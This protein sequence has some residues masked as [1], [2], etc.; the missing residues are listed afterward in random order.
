MKRTAL[1]QGV[2]RGAFAVFFAL[3]AC[4]GGTEPPK[5]PPLTADPPAGSTSADQGAAEGDVT[6]GE[7]LINHG[8]FEEAKA[9]LE[10]ALQR[11]PSARAHFGMGVVREKMKD[12]KGAEESYKEALKLDP[13]HAE[14]SGNL[15]ALYMDD[16]RPA[17]AIAVLKAATA[18]APKEVQLMRNLAYAYA[19]SG[20]VANAS[21]QYEAALKLGEDAQIRF[22][23][24]NMLFEAKQ[25]EKA[26]EQLK[27]ALPGT[28][29]DAPT[30]GTLG[31]LLSQTKAYGECVKAYD[32]AIK[33]KP[34]PEWLVRR[35]TCRHE[36]KDDTGAQ[37]DYQEAIKLDPKFATAHYYLAMAYIV[38]KQRAK[39]LASLE[40]AAKLGAG[41]P[42]GKRAKD[43]LNELSKQK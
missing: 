34:H 17:E 1:F 14:A 12:T 28:K 40:Q 18:K 3:A 10:K 35:G 9:E 38:D 33:L 32:R 6:R 23:Y 30:L 22:E 11:H 4:S 41:T 27:K 25:P 20:D 13:G 24:G 26:A 42:V 16:K 2:R 21:A 37:A 39:A 36:L 7:E 15:A 8:K 29:D 19:L 43:K 31:L 5:D